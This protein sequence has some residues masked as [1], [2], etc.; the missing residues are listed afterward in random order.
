MH[1]LSHPD[2]PLSAIHL[3]SHLGGSLSALYLLSHLGGLIST[4]HVLSQDLSLS[5]AISCTVRF[6]VMTGNTSQD[7][8]ISSSLRYMI[9]R[10]IRVCL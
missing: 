2:G 3:L 5:V 9:L 6:R 8:I 10:F 4:I 7:L 1:L